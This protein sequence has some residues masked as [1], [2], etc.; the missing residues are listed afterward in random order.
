MKNTKIFMAGVAAYAI[1]ILTIGLI[2]YLL[3]DM[4]FKNTMGHPALWLL[5]SMASLP[6]VVCVNMDL[7]K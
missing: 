7:D 4:T 1:T 5:G 3:N 2:A 6:A